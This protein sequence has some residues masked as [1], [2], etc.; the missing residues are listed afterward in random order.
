[1]PLLYKQ[2]KRS[3]SHYEKTIISLNHCHA[4]YE[5]CDKLIDVLF[6]KLYLD[7]DMKAD[8]FPQ[9]V[10]NAGDCVKMVKMVLAL[11]NEEAV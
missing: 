9:F 10:E 6:I 5:V 11:Q 7:Y 4:C 2:T 8:F 1:M 3:V